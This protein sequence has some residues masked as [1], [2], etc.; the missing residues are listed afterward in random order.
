M[1]IKLHLGC[2]S[3]APD[4]WINIDCSLGAWFAKHRVIRAIAKTTRTVPASAF[5]AHWP[6]NILVHD[7][8]KPLPFESN[9]VAAIYSSNML[10]HMYHSEAQTLLKECFRVLA[11]GGACRI[12]VPDLALVIKEYRAQPDAETFNHHLAMF[13]LSPYQGNALLRWYYAFRNTGHKFMYDERSLVK[14][15]QSAGF[16]DAARQ[17]L[18]ESLITDIEIIERAEHFTERDDLCVEAIKA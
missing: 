16:S 11:P 13:D 9:S 4:G 8:R 5:A 3:H 1:S 18:F 17:G 14:Q 10:E 12:V 7:L 6:D 2:G 15:F